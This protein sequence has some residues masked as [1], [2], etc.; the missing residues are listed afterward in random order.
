MQAKFAKEIATCLDKEGAANDIGSYRDAPAGL[1]IW[2]GSTVEKSDLEDLLPW[3]EWAFH[4]TR[5]DFKS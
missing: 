2:A 1:R 5:A 3:L 4:K